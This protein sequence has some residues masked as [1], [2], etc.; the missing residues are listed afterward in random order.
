[1]SPPGAAGEL[2]RRLPVHDI[3]DAAGAPVYHR[4]ARSDGSEILELR[5]L[6]R[7]VRGSVLE[8]ACGSGRLTL[9]LLATGVELTALDSSPAMIELLG[10]A[11]AGS[12]PARRMAGRLTAVVGDMADFAFE[13]RFAA[14]VLGT[15][16]VA[17][18]E[19]A[20]RRACFACVQ[21]HLAD[22]GRVRV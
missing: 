3:Y 5:S 11:V 9:P 15:T 6:L 19:A 8:L 4:L 16:S 17:L 20:Q 18:L 12:A 13:R 10:A 21:R 7:G 2:A 22:A 1:V 14:V